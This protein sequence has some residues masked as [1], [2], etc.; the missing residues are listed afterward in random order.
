MDEEV[1]TPRAHLRGLT[2]YRAG[3]TPAQVAAESGRA[4]IKLASNEAPFPPHPTVVAAVVQ[5]AA[6]MNRY[7]DIASSLVVEALARRHG[8]DEGT[9]TVDTGSVAL[10]H[11]LVDAVAGPGDEVVF[12]WPSFNAYVRAVAMAGAD[13]VR[14]ALDGQRHDLAAMAAA[15]TAR[16]KAVLVCNPNNPTSTAVRRGE[17]EQLLDALDPGVLV[18]LDE[19]YREYVT[20]EDVPDGLTLLERH[21]NLAVLRTFSKAYGLAGLRLG[22][23]VTSTPLT[24]LLRLLVYP[25]AVSSVAQAAAIACLDGE[26]EKALMEN[27]GQVVAERARLLAAIAAFGYSPPDSQ[28]NFVWVPVADPQETARSLEGRGVIVRPLDGGLR[29]TVGTAEENDALLAALDGLGGV[30]TAG[31]SAT[32]V[33]RG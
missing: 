27:V 10:I 24:R 25:F 28:A 23:C 4:A 14:V 2:Q 17:L 13:P 7:P 6:E 16:T 19:A 8:I 9:V 22:Y 30:P 33:G 26:V 1:V 11:H 18:V 31:R 12:A 5:A 32:E 20:D 3:R 29:I 15:T 21:P